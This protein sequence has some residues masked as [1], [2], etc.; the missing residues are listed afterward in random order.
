[1]DD[2]DMLLRSDGRSKGVKECVRLSD[3]EG[4][5]PSG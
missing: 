3:C 4:K 2:R 5:P 1:M